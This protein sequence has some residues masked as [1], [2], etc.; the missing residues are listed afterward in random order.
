MTHAI[1]CCVRRCPPP[2]LLCCALL[3]CVGVLVLHNAK[4][5]TLDES[6]SIAD[7]IAVDQ[8]SG[9]ILATGS[10]SECP[11]QVPALWCRFATVLDAGGRC[12]V[13]GLID[14]HLHFIRE[15]NNFAME[16]RWDGVRSLR[17]A[18]DMVRQQALRTPA[19]Q[20]VRVVGGWYEHHV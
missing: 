2:F 9:L 16:L 8:S 11:R 19:G 17:A 14:S 6:S 10:D 12:I 5:A 3:A 4:I 1:S 7:A 13:P 20:W 18:L 15:G